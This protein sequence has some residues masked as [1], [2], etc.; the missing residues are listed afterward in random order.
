MDIFQL[1]LN[2]A[3]KNSSL[4]LLGFL[5]LDHLII[6]LSFI[7]GN[8]LLPFALPFSLAIAILLYLSVEKKRNLK[9]TAWT[10]LFCLSSIA[11]S[12]LVSSFY[13]DLSWDGQWYHQ[14]A[15]YH[16]ERGWDPISE[17]ISTFERNNDTSII[18]FP[19]GSW[20]F[21]VSVFS[22]FGHFEAGKGVNIIVV[23]ISLFFIYST[24]REFEISG[25]RSLI[26]ST[27]V[28]LNPVVWSEITTYLVDG[29]LYLY[30]CIYILSVLAWHLRPDYRYILSGTMAVICA[31]NVKFTGLVFF[32]VLA[33]FAALYILLFKRKYFIRSV[34]ISILTLIISVLIFGYN[35]YITNFTERGHPLYPIMG[36]EEYPSVFERTGRDGNEIYETPH[37]M[38]GKHLLV[39]MFHANFGRPDNAPY[40]KKRDSELIWPFTSKTSDWKAYHF[41]ETR[42]SG[43]G[44]YFS[45]ILILS[46]IL[47]LI[48][49]IRDK[50]NR[51]I[52][53]F[54]VTS[55]F[56]TLLFSKHFWWPRF[57]PQMWLIPLVPISL[58]LSG[59]GNRRL[60]IYTWTLALLMI[61][62]GC[63]VLFYHMGWETRSSVELRRQLTELKDENSPIEIFSG[64][65]RKSI[66]EKMTEWQIQFTLRSR[67]EIIGGEHDSLT[68]VVEG[69][70]NM[71]LYRAAKDQ[72]EETPGT[73]N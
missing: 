39:R 14:S 4:V 30:L 32:C 49:L 24:L 62:N 73:G 28:I 41:H 34:G 29:I 7:A 63:I 22:T 19:K 2:K 50:G 43:F 58:A 64:Y 25:L 3:L 10:I 21:A 40:H 69:Y 33:A 44:P 27:L 68:S 61:I 17:P 20:Y 65:F 60:N 1:D 18:H 8:W 46:F 66:D 67:D 37:N 36:T 59:S 42:V 48:V 12:I 56:C 55:L 57:G 71:V 13:F 52:S 38:M 31:V 16:L 15:I 9:E 54:L 35:P 5:C 47:L 51:W 6:M 11:I 45:G 72:T 26:I 70:P 23:F 53:I